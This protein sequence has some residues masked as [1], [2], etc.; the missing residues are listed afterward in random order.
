M[1]PDDNSYYRVILRPEQRIMVLDAH[2]VGDIFFQLHRTSNFRGQISNSMDLPNQVALLYPLIQRF[3]PNQVVGVPAF[4]DP[5]EN[6]S[7]ERV[8]FSETL[9]SCLSLPYI[10]R[11]IIIH[12]V[13]ESSF[14]PQHT[15]PQGVINGVWEQRRYRDWWPVL[16]HY[17]EGSSFNPVPR[18]RDE[19][20]RVLYNGAL[21]SERPIHHTSL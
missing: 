9:H 12:R 13:P 2:R 3:G 17:Q 5:L 1:E 6:V 10:L 21:Y 18:E 14:P 20:G 8:F 19:Y 15:I 11:F 4:G 7:F 16:Q